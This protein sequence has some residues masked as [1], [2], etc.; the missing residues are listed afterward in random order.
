[1]NHEEYS[2]AVLD[3]LRE[4]PVEIPLI[5]T[6]EARRN[7][8]ARC[9][10]D[11]FC[12]RLSANGEVPRRIKHTT[13]QWMD[14]L[15]TL[16]NARVTDHHWSTLQ[17]KVA[18]QL[19]HEA[20][21][22][23]VVYILL[24]WAISDGKLH[25]WAIPEDVAHVAFAEIPAGRDGTYKTV[26]VFPDT[27]LMRNAPHAPD[28]SPYYVQCDLLDEE[29]TKLVE[30][31]KI[32]RAAKRADQDHDEIAGDSDSEIAD[33]EATPFFTTATV[34]FLKEL[35]DHVQDAEWH[36]EQKLRYQRVL[37]DPAR[38]LVEALRKQ[39]IERLSPEVA[40]GKRHL[41][42]LK[43]ND[44][45]KGGYHD[46][47]WFA[48]YD[49]RIGSKTRSVQ[50]FFRMIGSERVWRYGFGMGN[51]CD[52]YAERLQLAFR[53]NPDAAAEYIRQAPPEVRVRLSL[54][55]RTRL[56]ENTRKLETF[57]GFAGLM[58]VKTIPLPRNMEGFE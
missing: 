25:V 52:E 33:D 6:E 31:I 23:P 28:L 11:F 48:F 47:Y 57:R 50:F 41:S 16:R 10:T 43:K 9:M 4:P 56:A 49:P 34:E 40:G 12:N 35:P 54:T 32:D 27:H 58:G 51:Y 21:T 14:G 22:K 24:C 17:V 44:Y 26:E 3:S 39:Y 46:H 55:K 8:A 2:R 15:V 38:S 5:E 1:M 13:F 18:E 7:N 45:G 29:L 53:S 19:H 42:I 30:S 37:R 36:E 20:E